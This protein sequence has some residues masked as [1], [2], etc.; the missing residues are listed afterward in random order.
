MPS[1]LISWEST[2]GLKN[3][4]VATFRALPRVEKQPACEVEVLEVRVVWMVISGMMKLNYDEVLK[5]RFSGHVG[6]LDQ[7]K[8]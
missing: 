3:A 4:G 8:R 1:Q 5:L 6:L 2:S 7:N